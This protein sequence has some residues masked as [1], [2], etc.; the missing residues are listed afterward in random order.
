MKTR[1][2][3]ALLLAFSLGITAACG[4]DPAQPGPRPT[5][6]FEPTLVAL[7]TLREGS[8]VLRNTGTVDSGPVILGFETLRDDSGGTFPMATSVTPS[9]I[10]NLA[11]GAEDTIRFTLTPEDGIPATNYQT[12]LNVASGNDILVAAIV[13]LVVQ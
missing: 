10:A 3:P 7:D 11:A 5:L 12:T 13:N 4:G 8:F 9:S 6:Q 2:L 1:R